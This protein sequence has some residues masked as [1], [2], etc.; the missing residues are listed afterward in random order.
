ME[1]RK[2]GKSGLLVAPLVFGGNVFGWLANET[3]LSATRLQLNT[4]TVEILNKANE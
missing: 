4:A 3:T 2:P 1:K